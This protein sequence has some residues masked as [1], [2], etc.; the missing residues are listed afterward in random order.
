MDFIGMRHV[1]IE[2][3]DVWVEFEDCKGKCETSNDKNMSSEE[4]SFAIRSETM[5]VKSS[6]LD[7][8]CLGIFKYSF[9]LQK[10]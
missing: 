2:Y 10:S 4:I 8:T 3:A 5:A 7:G 1:A 6:L 9:K